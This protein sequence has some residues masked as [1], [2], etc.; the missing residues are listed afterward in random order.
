MEKLIKFFLLGYLLV[1]PFGQLVRLPI[2][3]FGPEVRVYLGDI[4][5]GLIVGMWRI[6]KIRDNRGK[7]RDN[8]GNRGRVERPI[9]VFAGVATLSLVVNLPRLTFNEI[10]V[11]S[12]YLFRW[13]VYAGLYFVV[14]DIIKLKTQNSKL[15]RN[16]TSLLDLLILAGGLAA[17]FGLIQYLW[18]PDLRSWLEVRNW[19]PHYYRAYGTFFDPGYFGAIMVLSLILV[20]GH[21][22]S[23]RQKRSGL[24]FSIFNFQFSIDS[25]L[26]TYHLS[27]ITSYLALALT[28]SRAS[29]LAFLVGMGV[30][31]WKLKK[32][33][34]YAAIIGIFL[35][36]LLLL[37]R[38]GGEGVKLE[39]EESIR[40]RIINWKQ[41][42]TIAKRYPAFGV[43][44][45]AYRY[46]QRDYGFLDQEE[47][48][49]SHAGAGADSSLLFVLAT[50]GVIGFAA[51]L[52]LLKRIFDVSRCQAD[53]S[54][55]RLAALASL[56]ALLVHSFFLNSL[57]YP[58]IMAWMWILLG[59][60]I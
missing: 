34:F 38:P 28:Y 55:W 27:L 36:T 14:R 21:L 18:F 35:L 52:W 43:G 3:F 57:F 39:R 16:K 6:G 12:F 30:V 20:A 44:F 22:F 32:R 5:V 19:D 45:N 26:I 33:K 58:W 13:I 60:I 8:K 25:R 48:R 4:L 17:I 23:D 51:Y 15:W 37:P 2:S 40:A 47:W 1:F 50:T 9:L 41:S 7:D 53:L 42:L 10:L 54:G 46:F 56:I 24:K 31:A 59:G 49:E 11:A 29:Y